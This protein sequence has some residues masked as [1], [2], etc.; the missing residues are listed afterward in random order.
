MKRLF[1]LIGLLATLASAQFVI[2]PFILGGALSYSAT[3]IA[4]GPVA[5][6]RLGESS[7]NFLDEIGSND[8]VTT[9]SI[10]FSQTSL[11]ASDT[12]NT[13]CS[14]TGGA[15]GVLTS[16]LGFSDYPVTLE[17]LFNSTATSTD[18][19][20][21]FGDV[22]V[23]NDFMSA[24]L[25][26]GGTKAIS[27]SIDDTTGIEE[28]N[29]NDVLNDGADYHVIAVYASAT[30]RRVYIDSVLDGSSAVS[31]AFPA[32]DTFAVGRNEDSSP[33]NNWVGD[34]D[35]VSI[36]NVAMTETMRDAHFA[37]TGNP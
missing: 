6:W 25:L 20:V 2:N 33:G 3:I 11:L 29:G 8:L 31:A 34:L 1:L 4:D 5:Y 15:R 14:F 22:S 32:V 18:T 13:A 21:F 26:G 28:T 7:G 10:T 35:E 27:A 12:G 23:G 36:W 9:G 16:A 37:A 30:D 24:R 19:A 17:F